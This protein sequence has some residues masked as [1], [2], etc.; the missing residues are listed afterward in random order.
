MYLNQN[1]IRENIVS[2]DY[3]ISGCMG[4]EETWENRVR[5]FTL[6]FSELVFR[7]TLENI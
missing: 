2:M 5:K 3:K 4:S 1:S 6:T 7:V